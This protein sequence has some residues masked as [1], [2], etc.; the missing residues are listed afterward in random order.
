MHFGGRAP[1]ITA[2]FAYAASFRVQARD[3]A[4]GPP[5]E[6]RVRLRLL[7]CLQRQGRCRAA[8]EGLERCGHIGQGPTRS[9][10]RS[11]ALGNATKQNGGS[12][13]GEIDGRSAVFG[14]S[15]QTLNQ[16]VA[17]S[18]PAAPTTLMD[19]QQSAEIRATDPALKSAVHTACTVARPGT[20]PDD[21]RSHTAADKAR[22]W[23]C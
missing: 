17:V 22:T 10:G 15:P 20:E 4:V 11:V 9:F 18:G 23:P 2:A 3:S 5:S 16:R 21:R 13:R 1:L 8:L 12:I 19:K 7:R 6:R 14:Q